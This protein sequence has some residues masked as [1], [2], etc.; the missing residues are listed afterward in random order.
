MLLNGGRAGETA[1]LQPASVDALTAPSIPNGSGL[2]FFSMPGS[3]TAWGNVGNDRGAVVAAYFD[4]TT[5]VGALAFGNSQ[6]TNPTV[7]NQLRPVVT[8]LLEAFR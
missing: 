6:N 1:L 2:S 3:D 8:R 7:F 4:R 5:G